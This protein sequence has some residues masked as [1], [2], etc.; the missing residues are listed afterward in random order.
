MTNEETMLRL[1]ALIVKYERFLS[2]QTAFFT[3]QESEIQIHDSNGAT[4]TVPTLH[5]L[6]LASQNP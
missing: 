5:A 4:I 3:S 1:E 6:M 2:D